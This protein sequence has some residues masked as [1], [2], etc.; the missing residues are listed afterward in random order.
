MPRKRLLEESEF[1]ETQ[2]HVPCATDRPLI[3][4][5]ADGEIEQ[6]PLSLLH[7]A[8]LLCDNSDDEGEGKL[9]C[10]A[11]LLVVGNTHEESECASLDVFM[12]ANN[13]HPLSALGHGCTK[14]QPLLCSFSRPRLP[15][16]S[17]LFRNLRACPIW[18]CDMFPEVVS[19]LE[20]MYPALRKEVLQL[21]PSSD[22]HEQGESLLAIKEAIEPGSPRCS[23]LPK[24]LSQTENKSV[25]LPSQ[26]AGWQSQGE[27]LHSGVWKKLSLFSGG[28]VVSLGRDFAPLTFT[29]V[30]AL[31]DAARLRGFGSPMLQAPGRAYLSLMLPGTRVRVHCG[32]S[33][34]RLRLHLP[35]LVPSL[36]DNVSLGMRV[37]HES[38]LG[39][40][41]STVLR[42]KEGRCMIFDDSYPHEVWY[43]SHNVNS[44]L[45]E[46]VARVVLVIDLWHPDCKFGPETNAE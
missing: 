44:K 46:Q 18:S 25:L 7:A 11:G 6:W 41:H 16:P 19:H 1:S 3:V 40:L 42:W 26:S 43:D 12:G 10:S 38:E 31:L 13:E 30:Q 9:D 8:E 4:S 21:L 32:P 14:H 33:N 34:H 22:E 20:K 28:H 17:F 29:C 2:E 45:L 23:P 5:Y 36:T 37:W 39:K 15:R 27:G 35:L 24:G